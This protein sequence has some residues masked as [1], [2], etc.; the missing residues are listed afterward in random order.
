MKTVVI[1]LVAVLAN[2]GPLCY[3]VRD[4]YIIC[5]KETRKVVVLFSI[6]GITTE[7]MHKTAGMLRK[8]CQ[9][10]FKITDGE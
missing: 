3:G 4:F 10:K 8:V 6:K 2:F 5:R 1:V 9:P 7:Q